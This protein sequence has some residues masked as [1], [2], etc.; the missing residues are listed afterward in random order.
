MVNDP[1][2]TTLFIDIGGVLLTNGWDRA[3]RQ[4]AAGAYHLDY[5]EMDERHHLTYDTYE[6]GKLT[7]DEYLQR[8]VFYQARSFS[9]DEFKNF[10]YSLSLPY[11][12]MLDLVHL[13]KARYPLKTIAVNNEG[14]ELNDYRIRQFSLGEVIDTFVSS[15]FVHFRKPDLDIFKIALDITQ[16]P[17]QQVAYIDDRP[18]F[19]EIAQTL[20]IRGVRHVDHPSTL[21][22][23]A[24]LG[25][26]ID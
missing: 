1:P 22:K 12:Q 17:P 15:C 21:S 8:V 3:A 25:L 24:E 20:G 23:L 13:L 7:L 4:H 18:M 9:M 19:V 5:A 2:I 26:K 16:S 11:D 6:E 10:M 14:R